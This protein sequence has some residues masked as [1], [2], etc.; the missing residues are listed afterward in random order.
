[1]LLHRIKPKIL[2]LNTAIRNL[3]KPVSNHLAIVDY[4][5]EDENVDIYSIENLINI[6][7]NSVSSVEEDENMI[8]SMLKSTTGFNVN[9]KPL[10]T[11]GIYAIAF[12]KDAS[13]NTIAVYKYS[14]AYAF[15]P[16]S[17]NTIY[18]ATV[19]MNP[20]WTQGNIFSVTKNDIFNNTV[21]FNSNTRGVI[22][23][24]V[25]PPNN[26]VN[27][28]INNNTNKIYTIAIDSSNNIY[29]GGSFYIND[30]TPDGI[31][32]FAKWDIIE[33]K[34][35]AL[36]GSNGI[37][38]NL[39]STGVVYSIVVV[40][41]N[42]IYVGG[43]FSYIDEN[44]PNSS[45]ASSFARWNGINWDTT[46]LSLTNLDGSPANVYVMK[47]DG[48]FLYIGGSIYQAKRGT[49]QTIR[50]YNVFRYN[51]T[52]P[53]ISTL[54]GGTSGPVYAMDINTAAASKCLYIGGDFASVFRSTT[55]S[56]APSNSLVVN[57]LVRWNIVGQGTLYPVNQWSR[58]QY[59]TAANISDTT[60]KNRINGNVGVPDTVYAIAVNPTNRN[61]VWVGGV[62]QSFS[63]INKTVCR[64][65]R[66]ISYF[67]INNNF[68]IS[69]W[70]VVKFGLPTTPVGFL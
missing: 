24:G 39:Q 59:S 15:L 65:S 6:D 29:I 2:N 42:D 31:K 45:L 7:E 51:T 43:Y 54:R 56:G 27:E 28:A 9:W 21:F 10:Q 50:V 69:L 4:Q 70:T 55:A 22:G 8:K 40:N 23:Q 5:I 53:G 30:G 20:S 49:G 47:R 37:K 68:K 1:M 67:N 66:F 18:T 62:F 33:Q 48:G 38:F 58:I 63:G 11:I 26:V 12:Y 52:T 64:A 3:T 60:V 46:L 34:W 13:N 16:I 19:F 61:I 25:D 41:Q 44:N 14:N 35:S 32:G 57:N 17:D 36:R